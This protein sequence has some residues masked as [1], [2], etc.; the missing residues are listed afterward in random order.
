M[1]Q[2]LADNEGLGKKIAMMKDM[3][4]TRELRSKHNRD[5]H[6]DVKS[7]TSDHENPFSTGNKILVGCI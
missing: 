1:L 4:V 5:G 7:E 2:A 6:N 3:E